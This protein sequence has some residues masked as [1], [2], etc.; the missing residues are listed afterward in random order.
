MSELGS[1]VN[2]LELDLLESNDV[3]FVVFLLIYYD[4][5]ID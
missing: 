1:V 3:L 4:V 5:T 2:E